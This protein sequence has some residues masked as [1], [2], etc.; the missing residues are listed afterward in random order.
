MNFDKIVKTAKKEYK[1]L[2]ES[3]DPLILIGSATCGKSAGASLI[4]SVIE[5]ELE[6]NG[7]NAEI[8]EVGCIGLCYAE[9]II[10]IFKQGR[11]GI[12][13]GNLTKKIAKEIIKS[14]ILD[15]DPVPEY[16]L[17]TLGEGNIGDIPLFFDTEVAGNCHD[18]RN[19]PQN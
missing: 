1:S 15:D 9:P 5:D 18:R 11:P 2:Y 3:E 6:K 7:K 17:G 19:C 16:A 14:Y 13:Y 12:V 10:T 4:K 8:I